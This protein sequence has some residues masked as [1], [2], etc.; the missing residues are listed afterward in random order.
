M[1]FLQ[2]VADIVPVRVVPT[3]IEDD[4]FAMWESHAIMRYL[5]ATRPVDTKWFP[6]EPRARAKVDMILDW[7]H[8]YVLPRQSGM[9]ACMQGDLG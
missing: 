4:G 2:T 9:L 5:A 3:M 8:G 6:T 1:C 7:H